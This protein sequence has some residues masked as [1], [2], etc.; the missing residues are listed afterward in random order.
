MLKQHK[1]SFL[2]VI[3][4]SGLDPTVFSAEMQNI[5]TVTSI[6]ED[7]FY[8]YYQSDESVFVIKIKSSSLKFAV[9][10][11]GSNLH[12]F[13]YK[14]TKFKPGFPVT[15]WSSVY[16]A[17]RVLA[18]F[19]DW[20]ENVA[21]LYIEDSDLPDYWS[22]IEMY[23]SFVGSAET[24][25]GEGEKFTEEEKEGARRSVKQFRALIEGHFQP[26]PEQS[27]FI[28]QRLDYLSR[29]VDRLSR[30]DWNGLAISVV[31]SIAVNLSVDTERGR[32]LF[33]LFRQSFE[34]MAKLLK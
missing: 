2:Q 11:S 7:F 18:E 4:D 30:F 13:M 16:P 12:K 33:N 25:A 3:R 5:G 1:N 26:T 8:H 32:L 21:K 10:T 9:R 29:A 20:L 27:E 17:R 22:Q 28:D 24:P 6:L 15:W 31:V 34:S 23:K 14:R 19:K